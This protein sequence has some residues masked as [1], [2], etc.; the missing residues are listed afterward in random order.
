M[1][2]FKSGRGYAAKPVRPA[3]GVPWSERGTGTGS[4]SRGPVAGASQAQA[5]RPGLP[6]D[7]F[8]E[9]AA[10]IANRNLSSTLAQVQYQRGQLGQTYGLGVD[11]SG[12]VFDDVTNPY[13][14]AATLQKMHDRAVRGTQTTMAARGQLYAGSL[15][16]AQNANAEQNLR[17][18]DAMIREFMA[19]QAQLKQQELAAGNAHADAMTAANAERVM[20]ALAQRPDPASV[21]AVP[22]PR[23]V[24]P[25]APVKKRKPVK[26]RR[27]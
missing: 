12:N 14:R 24:T 23:P 2:V 27:P 13:S 8:H 11:P 3:F 22:A 18:R 4:F 16:N 6:I 7:P 10:G 9:A 1:A 15:Q 26:G 19:A 17:G 21:P 20:R 5:P 25:P